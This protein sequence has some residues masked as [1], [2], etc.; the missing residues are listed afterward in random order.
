MR[1]GCILVAVAV[2]LIMMGAQGI[3]EAHAFSK[4][5]D[6]DADQFVKSPPQEGWYR[7]KNCKFSLLDAVYIITSYRSKYSSDSDNNAEPKDDGKDVHEVYIPVHTDT[8]AINDKGDYPPTNLVIKTDDPTLI[9]TVNE[10]KHMDNVKEEDIAKWMSA[11]KDRIILHKDIVGMVQTGMN[12]DSKTRDLIAKDAASVSPGYV[13][14]EEGRKPSMSGGLGAMFGGLVMAVLSLAY[15]A[16][17][18]LRL[19]NRRA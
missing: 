4:P 19:K 12:L 1:C 5:V 6:I 10:V 3:R 8:M 9:S 15:W 2:F 14:V 17:Y 11:N 13:I 16:S 18:L 7:I